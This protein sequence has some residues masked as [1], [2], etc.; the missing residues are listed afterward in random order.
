[1]NAMLKKGQNAIK[2]SALA[3]YGL[4]IFLFLIAILVGQDSLRSDIK[5]WAT[6]GNGM[7][8]VFLVCGIFFL[9]MARKASADKK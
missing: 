1:M 9:V 2:R 6:F 8:A 3:Y 5:A 7:A 4:A